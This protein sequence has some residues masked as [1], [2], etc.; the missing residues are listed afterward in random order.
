MKQTTTQLQKVI[1]GGQTGADQAGLIAA[2]RF[3]I[4]TGGWMPHGFET[5]DGPDPQL[6]DRHGLREHSGGYAERTSTNVRDADGTIRIAGT[7]DSLGERCTRRCIRE[8]RKP[9]IDVDMHDPIEVAEVVDWIRTHQIRV[10]NVAGNSR[11][12]SRTAKA[13]GIEEFAVEFLCQLFRELG[14][15]EVSGRPQSAS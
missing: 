12:K 9:Y 6:A 8:R 14:H 2:A 11:P 13:W 4:P 10:L 5:S 15:E 1:S 3:G 7:F